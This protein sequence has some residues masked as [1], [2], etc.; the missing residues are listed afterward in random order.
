MPTPADFEA[1]VNNTTVTYKGGWSASDYGYIVLTKKTN[2]KT[3]LEFTAV[4]YRGAMLGKLSSENIGRYWMSELSEDAS[5]ARFM[6]FNATSLNVT[7][8]ADSKLYGRNV[9]CVK[10]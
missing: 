2:S 9:R 7:T 1:L 8:S 10:E 4:G 5:K 3:T 6:G